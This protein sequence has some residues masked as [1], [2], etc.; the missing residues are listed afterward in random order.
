MTHVPDAVRLHLLDYPAARSADA[1]AAMKV[2]CDRGQADEVYC[3][4]LPPQ[5][6]TRPTYRLFVTEF[7][8]PT[9][10]LFD[11]VPAPS[12]QQSMDLPYLDYA[13]SNDVLIDAVRADGTWD[14]LRKPWFDVFVP[15]E[16][17][18]AFMTSVVDRMTMADFAPGTGFVLVFPHDADAFRRPRLRVPGDTS[19]VYLCD[20]LGTDALDNTPTY[21]ERVL[22][23][24]ATW[25]AEARAVGGYVYPIGS[26]RWTPD[27]WREHYGRT[28]GEVQVAKLRWDP[29][30][31]LTPGP[32]IDFHG[33]STRSGPWVH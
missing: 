28:W 3:M 8:P 4:V 19:R 20:V 33:V 11:R 10:T 23:R 17:V 6:E 5:D 27:D 29:A 24:N 16:H 7:G 32:G 21:P 18:E 9:D 14:R 2:L 31:V 1:F 25:A 30:G 13:V 26:Q 22:D 12:E 15:E